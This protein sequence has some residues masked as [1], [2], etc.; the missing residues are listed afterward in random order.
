MLAGPGALLVLLSTR[1]GRRI[2]VRMLL[3]VR[4]LLPLW[5]IVLGAKLL[6]IRTLLSRCYLVL[7]RRCHRIFGV[8]RSIDCLGR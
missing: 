8:V 6:R 4:V 5:G 7:V 2:C 3:V 1:L